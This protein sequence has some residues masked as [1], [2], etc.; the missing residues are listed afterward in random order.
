MSLRMKKLILCTIVFINP[1]YS[2]EYPEQ[3]IKISCDCENQN[4]WKIEKIP[5]Y[6]A[7]KLF[8]NYKYFMTQ[9]SKT[10]IEQNKHH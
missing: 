2:E 5:E 3:D 10:T 1:L 7:K 9:H 6:I 4:T 8:E